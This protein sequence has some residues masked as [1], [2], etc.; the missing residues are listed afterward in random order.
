M[1]ARLVNW[2]AGNT[3]VCREAARLASEAMEH[4]ISISQHLRLRLHTL[5]CQLCRRYV[6]QL[7]FLRFAMRRY[8]RQS[9][10]ADSFAAGL[11]LEARQ[12]IKAALSG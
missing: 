5:I 11:S 4:P 2:I 7:R 6:V 1:N 9:E 8:S 10:A 12:R 3:P